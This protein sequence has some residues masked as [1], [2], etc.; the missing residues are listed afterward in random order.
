[1]FTAPFEI[2]SVGWKFPVANCLLSWKPV[3]SVTTNLTDNPEILFHPL[4]KQTEVT[5]DQVDGKNGTTQKV[6]ILKGH[7]GLSRTV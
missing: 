3:F 6:P 5:S 4:P 1:M 2:R 7:A